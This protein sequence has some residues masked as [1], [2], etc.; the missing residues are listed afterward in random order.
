MR[1]TALLILG[2][3][4]LLTS[5]RASSVDFVII[6][7]MRLA[8]APNYSWITMVSDNVATF[9]MEGRTEPTGFT[10]VKMPMMRAVARRLQQ[11]NGGYL[12]A[13]FLGRDTFVLRIADVWVAM[14][15]LPWAM[16]DPDIDTFALA[17]GRP[18]GRMGTLGAPLPT[19]GRSRSVQALD[20]EDLRLPGNVH[21]GLTPP[22]EE[23]GVI[24]SSFVE[25]R[26]NADVVTGTLSELGA[27]LL[28]IRDRQVDVTPV[29][30]QGSFRL[31]FK[32]GQVAQYQLRL[33]GILAI[34]RK[35][36]TVSTLTTTMIKLIGTTTIEIPDEA[37][38][39][40]EQ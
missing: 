3:A 34:G 16:P 22:H 18:G 31:W 14:H 10:W 30:A 25:L 12:E 7:A 6:Q 5:G 35:A 27:A 40:L 39:L 15:A 38:A 24:V 37:R 8:E 1:S 9:T 32:D 2:C 13:I 26:I 36:S 20:D 17:R 11:S 33:D 21:L 4:S 29:S 28:L 23:I 19:R